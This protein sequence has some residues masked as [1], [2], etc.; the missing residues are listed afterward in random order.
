MSFINCIRALFCGRRLRPR[1]GADQHF[2]ERKVKMRD[3]KLEALVSV[4]TL[5]LADVSRDFFF[6]PLNK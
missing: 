1:L 3:L 6:S 4:L 2:R 5:L